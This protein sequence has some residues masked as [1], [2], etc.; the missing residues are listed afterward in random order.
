MALCR[1]KTT[2]KL[3]KH[4]PGEFGKL[5]ILNRAPALRCLFKKMDQ[6][7]ADQGLEQWVAHLS[8]YWMQQEPESVGTLYIDGHVRVYT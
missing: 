4:A 8:K 5:L 6:L 1:I 2:E 7:S 3:R